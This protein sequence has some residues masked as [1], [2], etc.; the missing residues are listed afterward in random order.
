MENK[1]YRICYSNN[2]DSFE[3]MVFEGVDLAEA[4][5]CFLTYAKENEILN[6]KLRIEYVEII[7][8]VFL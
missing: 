1:H 2:Y 5:N 3:E 4:L 7:G 6:D 8:G